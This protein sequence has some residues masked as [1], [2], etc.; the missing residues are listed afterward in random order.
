MLAVFFAWSTVG[1]FAAGQTD[2]DPAGGSSRVDGGIVAVYL[3][4]NNKEAVLGL[5]QVKYG[6]AAVSWAQ[7]Q[8][9]KGKYDF[10]SLER[11][12]AD[13][14]KRGM[15]VTV[16]ISGYIKPHYLFNEVPYVK[17]TGK[18]VASFVQVK[19]TEGTLM[20][21]HPAYERA[22]VSCLTA[23]RNFIAASPYKK[24]IF[25]LRMN[26]NPFGCET[27]TVSPPP[28]ARP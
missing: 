13:Y 10:S 26:F 7:I 3:K 24:S 8:P 11:Q 14:A 4:D 1:L 25:G 17:E 27:F 6:Q 22:F 21:W 9:E 15:R 23:F 12:L 16:E 19:N 20:F 18:E 28:A 2:A 5:P